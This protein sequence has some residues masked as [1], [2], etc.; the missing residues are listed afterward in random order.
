M[1]RERSGVKR[2]LSKGPKG[3]E[4]DLSGSQS[5]SRRKKR[6][7]RNKEDQTRETREKINPNLKLPTVISTVPK[8]HPKKLRTFSG[9]HQPNTDIHSLSTSTDGETLLSADDLKLNFWSI[10]H[11]EVPL[12]VLDLSKPIYNIEDISGNSL[13]N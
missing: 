4:L 12:V 6:T 1:K 3:K 2:E 7:F 10:E 8:L 13:Y 11:P 9:G 5:S